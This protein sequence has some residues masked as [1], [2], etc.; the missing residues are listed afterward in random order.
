MEG[1]LAE[2][3]CKMLVKWEI[4]PDDLKEVYVYGFELLFS[5]LTNTIIILTLGIILNQIICTI[6]F[7]IVF[8]LV[9][10]F[11]GGFHA[12]TYL[13]CKFFTVGT[14]LL[15]LLFSITLNV[16]PF[17]FI[18]LGI[19]AML[20]IIKWGPVE[21]PNKP[22]T[23]QDMKKHQIISIILIETLLIINCFLTMISVTLSNAVF[24]TL[25]SII[26]L[27]FIAIINKGRRKDN[28]GN[29]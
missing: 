5:F 3:M 2:N 24:Y 22:L 14:Y 26:A 23:S 7:L 18:I 10:R 21:N 20:V 11:T 16:K 29:C 27:M 19:I 13:H 6:S 17:L 8:I 1:R 25:L 28:E 4:I 15:V 12:Q 9:R